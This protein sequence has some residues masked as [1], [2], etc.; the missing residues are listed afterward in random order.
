M[1]PLKYMTP[2]INSCYFCKGPI[3]EQRVTLDYR[4]GDSLI[5][6]RDVPAGVCLQCGEKYLESGVYRELENIAKGGGHHREKIIV[7]TVVYEE[8]TAA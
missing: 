3:A 5:V 1:T 6:I 8:K 7:D 4:W 2:V